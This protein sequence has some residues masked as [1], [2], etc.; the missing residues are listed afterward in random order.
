[1]NV[2]QES[3]DIGEQFVFTR[4][5]CFYVY[6]V[7][8]L[9]LKMSFS[10][11]LVKPVVTFRDSTEDVQRVQLFKNRKA[12]FKLTAFVLMFPERFTIMLVFR[13]EF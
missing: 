7:L 11:F 1:M 3:S 9:F 5:Y 2:Q 12:C 13:M 10:L 6:H 4:L 8:V